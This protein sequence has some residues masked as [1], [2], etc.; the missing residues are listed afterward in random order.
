M[1]GLFERTKNWKI[2]GVIGIGVVI[3]TVLVLALL[4]NIFER[5][6]ETRN[7][8][9]R[10]VEVTE[11]DTDPAKWG[12]NWPKEYDSYKLTAQ[13]TRTRFFRSRGK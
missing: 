7:P 3:A 9:V 13:S 4:M 6:S 12:I 2:F 1:K 10:L 11:D 8:Y 5:K